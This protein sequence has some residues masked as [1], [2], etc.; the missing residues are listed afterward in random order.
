MKAVRF[1][2]YFVLAFFLSAQITVAQKSSKA[3]VEGEL[4]VKYKSGTA[5]APIVETNNRIGATVV[6]EFSDLGWQ[7]VKLPASLSVGKAISQYKNFAEVEAAQPNFIYQLAATPND[8]SF[9]SLY[10]M[11]KISAP[12]A[13]DLSTGSANVVVANIDTGVRYTHPDLAANM[14]R[15]GGETQNNG[16]DDDG[17][18]F[19]D[20]Y[21]GYDFF[22]NDSDP[23]DENGHGT[24]TAGTIG[25]VGNNNLGVVGVNWN[26][27]LMTIKIYDAAG[28]STSAI[29]INAYNYVRLMKNRGVNIRVTNNSY[30]GC[31]EACDYDQATK[32]AL[33]AL[34]N[35][36]VL[37]VFA[38]GNNGRNIETT[39]F[40]PA[41]YTSP[42]ILAVAASD[43]NDN[44]ASFSNFGTTSVDVAAP[45]VGILSTILSAGNYGT[46]S[47][48]SMASPH[49]A[50][51][52]ALLAAYNPNLSA[53]SLKATLM[54]TVDQLPQWNNVVKTGGR[55]N[56]ANALQNQT[57]CNFS[58]NKN[59]QFAPTKGGYFTVDVTAAPNCDYSVKS[60]AKWIHIS[61]PAS[62]SGNN[63]IVFRVSINPTITR[64]GT[65]TIAGV[66]FTVRQSRN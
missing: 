24:H 27:R 40:Y 61:N 44:R 1:T 16:I 47:G 13:W 25:A 5:D 14:W 41:S 50:G 9:G 49:T 56:V 36:D 23:L 11:Q 55:V 12:T 58:L 65:I 8:T 32:D 21:Y 59:S 22:S 3:F 63:T 38:A 29:L 46:S 53:A 2:I 4:L 20:D 45:G 52:A 15:N 54:N 43:Q 39:P 37:Q 26:V 35:A 19:I 17:N 60:N 66:A 31:A 28:N 7:R 51:S 62:L 33:D 10:G 30:G 34:G 48:T 18:G 64:T 6:E 57:V 42:S